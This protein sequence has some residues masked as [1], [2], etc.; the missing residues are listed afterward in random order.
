VLDSTS[1]RRAIT[2][3][4]GTVHVAAGTDTV[5]L[6]VR[7]RNGG[8]SLGC[9]PP[10]QASD[11]SQPL[12]SVDYVAGTTWRVSGLLSDGSAAVT[13]STD[14]GRTAAPIRSNVFSKVVDGKPLRVQW[15]DAGGKLHTESFLALPTP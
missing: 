2:D 13:I 8:G 1:I 6:A 10:E 12:L 15:R 5:C 7:A 3:A 4:Q 14:T 9:A 11:P